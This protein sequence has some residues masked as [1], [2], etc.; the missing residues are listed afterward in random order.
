[1]LHNI[2]RQ[3]AVNCVLKR[4]LT[5]VGPFSR[6]KSHMIMASVMKTCPRNCLQSKK[7]NLHHL[8]IKLNNVSVTRVQSEKHL[9]SALHSKFSFY[10]VVSSILSEVNKLT[11]VLWKLETFLPMHSLLTIYKVFIRPHLGYFG[12]LSFVIKKQPKYFEVCS[13]QHNNLFNTYN[14]HCLKLLAKLSWV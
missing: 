2:L 13:T 14:P 9:G 1:M 12:N 3:N 5:A 11:T 10:E 7:N 6:N 8:P 4:R